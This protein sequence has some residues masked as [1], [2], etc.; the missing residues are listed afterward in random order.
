M[1]AAEPLVV[2]TDPGG[3]RL[4]QSLVEELAA[5]ERLLVVCGRYE[6]V[7]ERVRTLVD[8]SVSIG[9]YVLT[10][11]EL[12]A[13]VLVDAVSRLIPGVLGRG[14]LRRRGVLLLGTARVPAVHAARRS[15]RAS[16]VPEVLRGGDHGKVARWR[17]EQAVE[18]TARLRP[19]LLD[20]A[21]LDGRRAYSGPP[22]AWTGASWEQLKSKSQNKSILP[23]RRRVGPPRRRGVRRR[24]PHH[25]V[26]RAAVRRPDRLDDPGRPA[27]RPRFW[28]RST[29]TSWA[30]RSAA[31]SSCSATG[32]PGEPDLLKRVIALPGETIS[33]DEQ[34]RFT[35]DG[36]ALE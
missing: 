31:T 9:D 11:G 27:R 5:R 34:G 15:S 29:P 2:L 12:P 25:D 22:R 17:R 32:R 13:M 23:D 3:E 8:R 33:M 4:D 20:A 1:D 26:R 18:R 30:N 16:S 7:D 21:D 6:G 36:K 35:I 14:D 28:S 10:G 19:D 24:A